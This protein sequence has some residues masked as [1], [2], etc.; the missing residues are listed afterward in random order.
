M[1]KHIYI[2]LFAGC[3][4]LSPALHWVGHKRGLFSVGMS[5]NVFAAEQI[6]SIFRESKVNGGEI[7]AH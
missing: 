5:F 6:H 3:G 2:D 1:K 7:E 4:G